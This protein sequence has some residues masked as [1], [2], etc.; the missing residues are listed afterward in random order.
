MSFLS[1]F[2]REPLEEPESESSDNP[3][4]NAR[5]SWNDHVGGVISARQTWQ[6]IGI[7]CL[8]IA[9]A[10]VGGLVHVARQ[11][12]FVPYIV[13]VD[14]LGQAVAVKPAQ[15][16]DEPADP[17]VV[18]ATIASFVSDARLVTPDVALQRAAVLRVYSVLGSQDPATH[19][20]NEYLNGN[21]EASPFKRA[22]KE[23]VSVEIT[24]VMPQ[25]DVTWQI[26]WVETA[27]DRQGS[28]KEPAYRMRALVTVYF[29]PSTNEEQ[30]RK[31]PF[32][33]FVRDFSWSR[34]G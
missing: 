34:Q 5:R 28:P 3:Y 26:D 18:Q 10:A 20:M 19:K 2:R 6:V 21:P 22:A 32:G 17:R 29:L 16:G 13:E 24:S 1:R 8:L 7:L 33:L 11:S 23:M 4:L 14:K 31:N 27:R 15:S 9:V 12:K 30:I 25:T